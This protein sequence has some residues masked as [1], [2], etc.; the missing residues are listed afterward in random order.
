MD[1]IKK[2]LR[3]LWVGK[4]N[5]ITREQIKNETTKQNEFVEKV[6]FEDE[7]CRL[8]YI[9]KPNTE[10]NVGAAETDQTAKIFCDTT[11]D[12]PAGAKIVITQ[13][14]RVIEYTQSGKPAFYTYHQEIPVKLFERW[15]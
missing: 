1:V 3:S 10:N 5:V 7:P 15:A 8:S 4:M 14:N 2:A 6:I 12:I 9:N 11:L 13:N